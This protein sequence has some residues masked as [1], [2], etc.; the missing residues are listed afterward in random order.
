MNPQQKKVAVL[1][2][3]TSDEPVMQACLDALSYFNIPYEMHVLSAHRNPEKVADF[4]RDA[5]NQGFHLGHLPEVVP[6]GSQHHAI[7]FRPALEY[8]RPTADGIITEA[9]GIALDLAMGQDCA[10]GHAQHMNE[11]GVR[12]VQ[13]DSEGEVR[14]RLNAG[15]LGAFPVPVLLRTLDIVEQVGTLTAFLRTEQPL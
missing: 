9:F 10:A 4:T 7:I 13:H 8:V 6:V 2:G 1:M 3:S 11:R 15:K 12:L 5:E 14:D